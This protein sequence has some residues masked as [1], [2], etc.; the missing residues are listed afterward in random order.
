MRTIVTVATI[1]LMVSSAKAQTAVDGSISLLRTGWGG[2]SFALVL[3]LPPGVSLPD[4]HHCGTL[5]GVMSDSASPGYNTFYA[6]ALAAFSARKPVTVI[7]N[8]H[9]CVQGRPAI[10]GI[11]V[12]P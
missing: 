11:N 4:P 2:D 8:D 3:K 12:F 9:A 7:L 5:D 10:F 1:L 6:A